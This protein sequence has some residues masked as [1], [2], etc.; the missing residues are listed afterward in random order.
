VNHHG[1]FF[2]INDVR[3]HPSPMQPAGPPIVVAG[4]KSA[5][6]RRAALMGDGWM[7]Y[8][9]SPERYAASVAEIRR[10]AA[11]IGRDLSGF[12]WNAFVFVN[13]DDDRGRARAEAAAFFG[14]TFKQDVTSFLDRVAAVGTPA[15][16][17]ARLAEY[18]AA[19]ARHLLIAP[20][21]SRDPLATAQ[22][23]ADEVAP[24]V[25]QP[26]TD[27]NRAASHA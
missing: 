21:S 9:Y 18:V 20:T 8:L 12:Q 3:I 25:S 19:G 2:A 27:I 10:H 7:P 15:E 11:G 24:L 13:V 26:A 1:R 22:H 23:F 4:R 5:A 6:M 14:G 16:V 17:A